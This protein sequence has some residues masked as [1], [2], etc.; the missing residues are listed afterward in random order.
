MFRF[1]I[2]PVV[3]FASGRDNVATSTL[4][5]RARPV[6]LQESRE[7]LLDHSRGAPR[8][9]K[10]LLEKQVPLSTPPRLHSVSLRAGSPL[11]WLRSGRDDSVCT[12]FPT[13]DRPFNEQD[14]QQNDT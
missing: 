12:G 4:R 14:L 2:R 8:I 6:N 1:F 13:E 10:L 11:G 7:L 5:L 9:P 3:Q